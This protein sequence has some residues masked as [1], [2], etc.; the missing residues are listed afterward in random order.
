MDIFTSNNSFS[1]ILYIIVLCF[2]M[3]C[4]FCGCFILLVIVSYIRKL[5]SIRLGT[6][7][8]IG[9]SLFGFGVFSRFKTVDDAIRI[10][11][12]NVIV[13]VG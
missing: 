1:I 5:F 13:F 2:I 9:S 6:F 7:N 8:R 4:L 10:V 11:H 12:D 3:F